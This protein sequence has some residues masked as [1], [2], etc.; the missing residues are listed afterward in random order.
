MSNSNTRRPFTQFFLLFAGVE[1][2]VIKRLF[3]PWFERIKGVTKLEEKKAKYLKFCN[4]LPATMW[5]HIKIFLV[6]ILHAFWP[7]KRAKIGNGNKN[8]Y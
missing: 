3:Q 7:P 1:N 2:V 6:T 8:V 4:I 5:G